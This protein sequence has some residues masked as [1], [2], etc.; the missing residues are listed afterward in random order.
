MAVNFTPGENLQDF[1]RWEPAD[2]EGHAHQKIK[3]T[4]EE[5]ERIQQEAYREGHEAGV[6]AGYQSGQAKAHAEA[7]RLHELASAFEAALKDMEQELAHELL[8][9]SLDIAKQMLRQAIKVKPKLLLPVVRSA[10]ESLPQ[11]A[12]HP[13]LH[14]HPE[15]AA[16]VREMLSDELPTA[17]WKIVEDPR[18]ARGGCLIETS[19]AEVDATLPSRWHRLAAALGQDSS[20]LDDIE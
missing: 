12:Q 6:A 7:E 10:M 14:L 5:L 1:I 15:D 4:A 2:L 18:I 17:G 3:L 9:L 16:L 20:W 8:A 11:N 13:H 19:T